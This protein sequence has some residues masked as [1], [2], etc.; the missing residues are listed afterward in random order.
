[1]R[2]EPL[3]VEHA[4]EIAPLLDDP[5]LHVFIGGEP[6]SLPELRDRYRRQVVGH[7][8]DGSQRWL[9]W[10]V[11]R[12]D[13]G[14]AVGTVQATVVSDAES[15]TAEVA[16]VVGTAYQGSGYAQEAAATMV[17]W[18]R[19]HHVTVIVAHVHADHRS[20]AAV[21]RALGLTPTIVEDGEVRWV[22]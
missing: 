16:W 19:R 2:L 10:I 17:A 22:G 11:R 12:L 18:L 4:Q 5:G 14:A 9:N 21:A 15:I 8:P 3:R 7:S 6:A 1:V 13:D 20:S